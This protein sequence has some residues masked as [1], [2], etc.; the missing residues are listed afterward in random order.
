MKKK[1][2]FIFEVLMNTVTFENLPK[3][4]FFFKGKVNVYKVTEIKNFILEKFNDQFEKKTDWFIDLS[5]ISHIDVAAV[6]L[7]ISL[8]IFIKKNGGNLYFVNKTEHLD[9]LL[10][11]LSISKFNVAN[12]L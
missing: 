9:N 7:L 4:C 1:N 2:N 3:K 8:N 5:A 6:Q 10:E 11:M 12:E